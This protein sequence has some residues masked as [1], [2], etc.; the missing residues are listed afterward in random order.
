MLFK[1]KIDKLYHLIYVDIK[2]NNPH[3]IFDINFIPWFQP[4]QCL[5]QRDVPFIL[6]SRI[7]ITYQSWSRTVQV[8]S[9]VNLVQKIVLKFSKRQT[10]SIGSQ[11]ITKLW[12]RW[13]K[14]F[15]LKSS[16]SRKL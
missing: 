1:C 2:L 9:F 10:P 15:I 12:Q 3:L 11:T 8:I 13:E 6:M 7:K 16:R 5:R 14:R 4:S